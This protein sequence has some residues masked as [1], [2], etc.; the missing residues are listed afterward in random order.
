MPKVDFNFQG[1]VRGAD[2]KTVTVQNPYTG[3][4]VKTD[5]SHADPADVAHKLATGEYMISLGDFLYDNRKS[6]IELTDF[7]VS[8]DG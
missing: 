2:I 3:N 7:E 8:S 1:W 6:E 4:L 5:V